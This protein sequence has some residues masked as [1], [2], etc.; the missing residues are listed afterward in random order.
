[1]VPFNSLWATSYSTS[2]DPTI[3]SVTFFKYL[4]CN[5][6]ELEP[7]QGHPRS[8]VMLPIDSPGAVSYSASIDLRRG[9][10]PV[11]R[12]LTLKLFFHRTQA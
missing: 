10:S 3:I 1:M 12:Y 11:S 6:D 9:M 2:I 4:T 8:K 5:F 7:V